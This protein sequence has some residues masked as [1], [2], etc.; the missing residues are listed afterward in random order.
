MTRFWRTA[1][2]A[3]FL[4]PADIT[5]QTTTGSSEPPLNTGSESSD[6]TLNSQTTTSSR[7]GSDAQL[8][9]PPP[10]IISANRSNRLLLSILLL[11]VGG[12]AISVYVLIQVRT[13]VRGIADT[14]RSRDADLR[15]SISTLRSEVAALPYSFSIKFEKLNGAIETVSS[16]LNSV[17]R[18][19]VAGGIGRGTASGNEQFPQRKDTVPQRNREFDSWDDDDSVSNALRLLATDCLRSP[20]TRAQASARV[21]ARWVV[22]G[23]GDNDGDLP[24]AFVIRTGPGGDSW[25]VPNNRSWRKLPRGLFEGVGPDLPNAQIV[26]IEDLPKVRRTLSGVELRSGRP[27]KVEISIA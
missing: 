19:I 24:D 18:D 9:A 8:K 26:R 11:G 5:G 13:Y 10:Q 20:M 23:Y 6:S 3:A 14:I 15:E 17:R 27:G 4:L 21:S 2:V 1:S 7:P 25:F 12:F 22:D 16:D